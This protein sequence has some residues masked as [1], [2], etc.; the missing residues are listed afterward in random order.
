MLKTKQDYE[1]VMQGNLGWAYMQQG[2]YLAAE[3]VY[4]KAQLIDPDANKACNLCLCLIKQRQYT[5]ARSIVDDILQGKLSGSDDPKSGNRAQ[6]LLGQIETS[7]SSIVA[8]TTPMLSI[9]DAFS[10]GLD[11]LMSQLKQYK[12]RRLPIFEELS[13]FR[14]QLAC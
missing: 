5:E 7:K 14:D 12:T 10:E 2:N 13:Q 6:E 1:L 11:Q 9:E 3:A 8:S 4:R